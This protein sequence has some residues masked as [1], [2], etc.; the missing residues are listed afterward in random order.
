MSKII[1][2]DLGARTPGGILPIRIRPRNAPPVRMAA[3]LSGHLRYRLIDRAGKVAQEGET[4]NMILDQGLDQIPTTGIGVAMVANCAVGTDNTAPTVSDTALGAEVARTNTTFAS[5]SFTRPSNGTYNIVK[6]FEFGYSEANGNLTEFGISWS[7]ST[8]GY[9]WSRE[10]FRNGSGTPETVTKTSAYK[11]H[12]IYELDVALTPVVMTAGSFNITGIGA[13]TGNYMLL[14]GSDTYNTR[15]DLGVFNALAN[16]LNTGGGIY[17]YVYAGGIEASASDHSG[18]SYASLYNLNYDSNSAHAIDTVRDAYVAGTFTR[19]GGLWKWDTG[20]ANIAV[21]AF[22]IS[23]G[24]I[25]T[26]YGVAGYVFDFDAGSVFTKDASHTL[27]IGAP[28]VTWGR[29]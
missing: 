19:T 3:G 29:A 14:K 12:L 23:G 16:A 17:N 10:L 22:L 6:S 13:I 21:N 11:L 4:H 18:D 27:T 26:Y 9:L 2:P 20:Y 15:S 1:T 8:P 24:Y 28:T 7:A 25:G 5:D